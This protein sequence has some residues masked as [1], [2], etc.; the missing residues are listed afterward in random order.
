MSIPEE[1]TDAAKIDG[2][3]PP[4]IFV[5]IMLPLTKPALATLAVFTFMANWNSFLWPLIVLDT[6]EKRTLPLGLVSFRGY[7]A[8]SWN[9]LMAASVMSLLPV[10]LIFLSA[11]RYFTQGISLTGLKA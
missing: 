3:S 4:S 10:I 11:Q 5:R 6:M 2:A 7:Y 1:L 9:L 8:T